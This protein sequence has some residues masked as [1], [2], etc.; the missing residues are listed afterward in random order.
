MFITSYLNRN[1][2]APLSTEVTLS[3]FNETRNSAFEYLHK[4]CF[5]LNDK[6]DL[7][8]LFLEMFLVCDFIIECDKEEANIFH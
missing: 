8:L 7:F 1:F 3:V 6:N 4:V 5:D 2:V